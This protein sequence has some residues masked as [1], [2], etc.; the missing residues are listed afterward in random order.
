MGEAIEYRAHSILIE[1]TSSG[2]YRLVRII[3][4]NTGTIKE[5]AAV[6]FTPVIEGTR[7]EVIDRAKKHIDQIS[8]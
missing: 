6:D 2:S 3:R 8:N 7:V 4:T 1:E 5:D